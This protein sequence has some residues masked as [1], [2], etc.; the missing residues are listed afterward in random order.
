[1]MA[2]PFL[3]RT[4][5]IGRTG[6]ESEKKT[7]KS[8]KGRQT[9]ASGAM[10][11]DKGDIEFQL[12]D[13]E[14]RA[15]NKAT[16]KDFYRIQYGELCKIVHEAV[17]KNQVPAFIVNFTSGNGKPRKHGRWLCFPVEFLK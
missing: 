3:K 1:M 17:A 16:E 11:G 6:I 2:N 10:V 12:G 5:G 9:R 14:I 15:E 4:A 8:L 7:A 13:M